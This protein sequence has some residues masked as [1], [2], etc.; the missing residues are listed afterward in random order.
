MRE[1]LKN[2]STQRQKVVSVACDLFFEHG[3]NAVTMDDVAHALHMSKRTLYLLFSDKEELAIA[4]HEAMIEQH[5]MERK[6]RTADAQNVMESILKGVECTMDTLQTMCPHFMHDVLK[7]PRL[8]AVIE[9]I[10]REREA[11]AVEFLHRGV[12]EGLLRPDVNYHVFYNMV[13][14]QA[15]SIDRN[16]ELFQDVSPTEIYLST[17]FTYLRG[18]TTDKGRAM[19]EEFMAA[20]KR[21]NAVP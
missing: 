9:R 12:A 5:D 4:C 14:F 19:L 2:K 16:K 21:E 6:L 7:Y 15:D 8:V 11:T 3:L 10:R 17:F 1:P 18:C 13:F 20:Y